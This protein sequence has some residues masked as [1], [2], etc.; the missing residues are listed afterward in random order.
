MDIETDIAQQILNG[1]TLGCMY[2]LIALGYT[3]IFGVMR[4]IFFAQGDLCMV[5]ALAATWAAGWL[6]QTGLGGRWWALLVAVAA[7]GAAAAA[8]GVAAERLTIRPLRR[9]DR[10]KQLIG[11]LGVSMV[12]QNFC[13]LLVSSENLTFPALLPEA[14][15]RVG[16][17]TVGAVQIFVIGCSLL[18]MAALHWLLHHTRLGLRLRAVAESPST[19]ELDGI[20]SVSVIRQTFLIG[21]VLA[22]VAGVM[23][24]S[25][26]GVAKYNMGFVPGIKGFTAAVLGGFGQPRG[27]MVGGLILGVAE[28]LAAGY[29]SSTYK[30]VF[31]FAILIFVLLM[32]PSGLISSQS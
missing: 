8:A 24:G 14:T 32:R 30:D 28:T 15:L 25:Y 10:T 3:L 31:A 23:L 9:A 20:D 13:M 16:T 1:L 27:A 29:V 19:S 2:A 21:S 12:I 7:A 4:L 26:D 22:G 18:L 6:T 17:T 11:S 5:G